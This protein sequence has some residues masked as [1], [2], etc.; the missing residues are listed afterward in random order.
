M[1]LEELH[2]RKTQLESAITSTTQSVW[3]LQGHK[4]EVEYQISGLLKPK[5][6]EIKE[7]LPVE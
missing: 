1:T 3:V 2:V 7:D 4:Q 5:E 6:V